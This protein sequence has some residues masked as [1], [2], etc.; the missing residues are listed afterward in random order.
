MNYCYHPE[1]DFPRVQNVSECQ[2]QEYRVLDTQAPAQGSWYYVEYP[3]QQELTPPR[4]YSPE[5]S[6][7]QQQLT[8][9]RLYSPEV[10]PVHQNQMY[11]QDYSLSYTQDFSPDCSQNY[12]H[13]SRAYADFAQLEYQR[14]CEQIRRGDDQRQFVN[15][16][17][18]TPISR[19][20]MRIEPFFNQSLQDDQPIS[21]QSF[22][23]ELQP[24]Y[25]QP[26]YHSRE[27]NNNHSAG[28]MNE[29]R[30]SSYKPYISHPLCR[31]NNCAYH[32]QGSTY[33]EANPH[34]ISQ[35]EI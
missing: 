22:Q 29:I 7:V 4:L 23:G 19:D 1:V 16:A 25:L 8:P 26:F 6:P 28:Q 15:Y 34:D 27:F 31:H 3:V 17:P 5:V 10:S 33:Y 24:Q 12:Y 30:P 2:R 18:K 32:D 14:A 11:T 35:M 20:H 13:D 21:N 9:P